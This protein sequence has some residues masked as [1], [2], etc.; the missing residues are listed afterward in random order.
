MP[1]ISDQLSSHMVNRIDR[2]QRSGPSGMNWS[3]HQSLTS[4]M[5]YRSYATQQKADQLLTG[6]TAPLYLVRIQS[7]ISLECST[8]TSATISFFF[9]SPRCTVM[10]LAYGLM[11]EKFFSHVESPRLQCRSGAGRPKYC[12]IVP[13]RPQR[14]PRADQ[15]RLVRFASSCRVKC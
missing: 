1:H 2:H 6:I 8:S 10:M 7:W 3:T 12:S 9:S 15:K 4:S 11:R 5:C 14:A 13:Q